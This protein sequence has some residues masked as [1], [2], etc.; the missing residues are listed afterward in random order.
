MGHGYINDDE[1][2]QPESDTV[3]AERRAN[4]KMLLILIPYMFPLFWLWNRTNFP[5]SF[6]VHTDRGKAGVFESWYYSYLLLERHKPLDL[7]AFAYMWVPVVGVVAWLVMPKL[8]TANFSLY[9]DSSDA[10]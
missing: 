1:G 2:F 4:W 5:D 7:V 8:R 3:R 10:E 6:G 9:S